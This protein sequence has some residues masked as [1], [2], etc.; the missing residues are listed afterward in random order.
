MKDS[1]LY[2]RMERVTLAKLDDFNPHYTVKVL[3]AFYKMGE[4]SNEFYDQL[5]HKIIT[6][7]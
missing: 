2:K 5:I 6:V 1:N 7:L 3:Q 4:G